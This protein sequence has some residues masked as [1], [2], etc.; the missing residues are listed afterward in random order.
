MPA[1]LLSLLPFLLRTGAFFG[2]QKLAALGGEKLAQSALPK[3]LGA[4]TP[5]VQ[6]A[7]KLLST[8]IGTLGAGFAADMAA[9]AALDKLLGGQEPQTNHDGVNRLLAQQTGVDG[10]TSFDQ[11]VRER[12]L[13]G[14]LSQA[15]ERSGVDL[16]RLSGV[17]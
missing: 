8:G 15:L 12:Q 10:E 2:G 9:G 14:T 3:V 4:L 11:M 17:L 13:R 16:N 7:G 5:A 1:W 6:G